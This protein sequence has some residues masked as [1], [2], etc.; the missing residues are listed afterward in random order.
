MLWNPHLK[1]YNDERGYVN[2]T[3]TKHALTADFGV[4]DY[5]FYAPK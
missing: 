5:G 3:I 2:A 4:L 1:S